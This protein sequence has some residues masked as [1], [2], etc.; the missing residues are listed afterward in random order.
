MDMHH[1]GWMVSDKETG[2]FGMPVTLLNMVVSSTD[3]LFFVHYLP[4]NSSQA[5]RK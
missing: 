2:F 1:E 5:D 4:T 3:C